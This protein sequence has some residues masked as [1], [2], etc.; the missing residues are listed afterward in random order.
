MWGGGGTCTYVCMCEGQRTACGNW[1]SPPTTWVPG[2]K[3]R[4]SNS[5]HPS[6]LVASSFIH[7]TIS[8]TA[9]EIWHTV[10]LSMIL[11][12]QGH[13]GHVRER[14]HTGRR[15]SA[16]GGYT[17]PRMARPYIGLEEHVTSR[18]WISPQACPVAEKSEIPSLHRAEEM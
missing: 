5:G 8:A 3:L 2:I 1:L 9:D 4:G 12:S 14:K 6:G 16:Q 13:S 18:G 10:T 7:R 17:D 15:R 11:F